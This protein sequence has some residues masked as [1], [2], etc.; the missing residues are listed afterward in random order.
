LAA[1]LDSVLDDNAGDEEEED[2]DEEESIILGLTE[3]HYNRGTYY[4]AFY[5]TNFE[6][7]SR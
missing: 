7:P 3:K 5:D 6:R 2:T 1:A 4:G